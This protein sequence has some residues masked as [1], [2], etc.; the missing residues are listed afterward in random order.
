M[1]QKYLDRFS[2]TLVDEKTPGLKLMKWLYLK[3]SGNLFLELLVKRKFL[4]VLYGK[5]QD[6]KISRRKIKNFVSDCNIDMS[7]FE[8]KNIENFKSF[9]D[10]F[11]RKL[12]MS[13]R[14]I[15]MNPTSLISP[16]DSK[17]LFLEEIDDDAKFNIKGFNFKLSEL[18]NNKYLFEKFRGGSLAIFRLAP[19]D[20][21]RF[22]FIDDCNIKTDELIEGHY[23]S[24]H[25]IAVS[26]VD[27]LYSK[28]KRE[29]TIMNTENFGDVAYIEVGATFVGSIIQTYSHDENKK[30]SEKGYFKFGGSTVIL[31]FEKDKVKFDSDLIK[32][33]EKGLET[34]VH[35]GEKVG[36][37]LR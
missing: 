3:K 36:T 7:L 6:L 15:D 23:Y 25:P 9:N 33:T 11:A 18:L 26:K 12:D 27:E 14:N 19:S 22:H 24:V 17:A 35:M 30:G 37:K 16:A 13:K 32:N 29:I 5:M 21:H 34:Y 31:V 8:E 10:F 4:S 20:Y 28:N 1:S 2:G